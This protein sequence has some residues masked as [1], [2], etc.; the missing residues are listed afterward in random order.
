M[1]TYVKHALII[2]EH[3]MQCAAI[4]IA[5][6]TSKTI[7]NY[8]SCNNLNTARRLIKTNCYCAVIIDG[9][10]KDAIET[11]VGIVKSI[12]KNCP[13][14]LIVVLND[15]KDHVISSNINLTEKTSLISK[16]D[17]PD[18]IREAIELMKH[19]RNYISAVFQMRKNTRM[20]SSLPGNMLLNEFDL[21]KKEIE[22]I[23]LIYTGY[24]NKLL[25]DCL[26]IVLS[27]LKKHLQNI[28]RKMGVSGKTEMLQLIYKYQM[29]S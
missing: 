23:N 25:S 19:G 26:G 1:S 17:N 7:E 8:E 18:V 2:E 6:K 3:S 12:Q 27:T 21:T 29:A 9:Q 24:S 5:L 20:N 10:M 22:I 28:Y 13:E 4:G 15:E 14:T 11:A 16:N